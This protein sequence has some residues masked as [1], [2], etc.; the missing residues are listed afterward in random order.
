MEQNERDGAALQLIAEGVT[1]L[2]GFDVAAISVVRDGVLHLAAVAGDDTAR[3][4][5][6][7][8]STPVDAV[9]AELEN[10]EDWGLLK[11][12]PYER[13]SGNLDDYSWIPDIDVSDEPD[14][15]HPHDLLCAL[16]HDDTGTLRGLLSIDVPRNGRRPD[17]DQRRIL[18]LYASQAARAVITAL[19][20]GDYAEGLAREQAVAEY[21]AQLMDVLSHEVLNPLTAILQNAEMLLTEDHHDEI[22]VQGLEAIQRGA[23]RIE[24]MGR[25]LLVLARVGKPDRPLDDLVDLVRL[26]RGV[27]E[28]LATEAGVRR[29]GVDVVTDAD[30]LLVAGDVRDLDAVLMNLVANAIKYSEPDERVRI[31]LACTQEDGAS[32]AVV[33]V[34]DRGVGIAEEDQAR[35]FEEFFRSADPRVRLRP[36]TGLGLAIAERAVARHGGRIGVTSSPRGGTRFRVTLPLVEAPREGE[37]VS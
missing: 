3:Q 32:W 30:Q 4:E 33:D 8:L 28:L 5:L 13:E 27:V 9:L 1:E 16:L 14:A 31:H 35:V 18:Q 2:A 26:T 12:V 34:V 22:V 10:A 23:R 37:D 15:W 21:R 20:R 24:S 36:G 11:F 17:K 29:I 7:R 25:D 19:E 6:A